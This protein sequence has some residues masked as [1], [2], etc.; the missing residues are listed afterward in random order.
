MKNVET[1]NPNLP[2]TF[3]ESLAQDRPDASFKRLNQLREHASRVPEPDRPENG[4]WHRWQDPI[5]ERLVPE[6]AS[7]LD[8]GCGDGELLARLM[9]SKAVCAQGVELSQESVIRCIER[10]VPVFHGNLDEGLAGFPDR[11]FDVV[12]LEETLQTLHQPLRVLDEMLRVGRRG[13]V[14]FPNFAHWS[15]RIELGLGGRMPITGS[16]PFRWHDTPNIHLFSIR[17]FLDWARQSNTDVIEAHVLVQDGVR[18]IR[19]EDNLMAEEVL[20]VVRRP[21]TDGCAAAA[22]TDAG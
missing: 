9:A 10:G 21:P 7:V 15:V 4:K 12:V 18:P 8:L 2:K 20:F 11:S 1:C 22:P 3:L 5:I 14:S 13:I 6:H 16:L 19:E 17:D